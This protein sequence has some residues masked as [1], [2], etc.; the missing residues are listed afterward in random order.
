MRL[1]KATLYVMLIVF[2]LISI[3]CEN[4]HQD[5]DDKVNDESPV[6]TIKEWEKWVERGRNVTASTLPN[7]TEDDFLNMQENELYQDPMS[8]AEHFVQKTFNAKTDLIYPVSDIENPLQVIA[9]S[10]DNQVYFLQ[11][12]RMHQYNG[13]WFVARYSNLS[14]EDNYNFPKPV[15]YHELEIEDT[16]EHVQ[17]WA[18]EV[19][20]KSTGVLEMLKPEDRTTQHLY[21]MI[22]A[23][24]DMSIELQRIRSDGGIFS[25][26]YAIQTA[27]A[28]TEPKGYILWEADS[29]IIDIHSYV[30]QHDDQDIRLFY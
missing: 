17:Q 1:K 20:K 30:K 25:I 18:N 19:L 27:P 4:D 12:Q 8:S 2:L 15:S 29:R 23:P 13:I 14:N 21:L 28:R 16:P 11:L 6:S 7:Y 5:M 9:F 3:G 24:E 26:Q 10:N 22:A